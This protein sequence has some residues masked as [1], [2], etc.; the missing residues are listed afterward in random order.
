MDRSEHIAPTSSEVSFIWSIL[1]KWLWVLFM[2]P[3][4]EQGK[5]DPETVAVS[6]LLK[7]TVIVICNFFMICW[8]ICRKTI[9]LSTFLLLII[10]K[11]PKIPKGPQK[12]RSLQ[13]T[14]NPNYETFANLFCYYYIVNMHTSVFIYICYMYSSTYHM[15]IELIVPDL[16]SI[17]SLM[18]IIM[19]YFILFW[20]YM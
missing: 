17:I 18:D 20:E 7:Y 19:D 1:L 14:I 10:L 12:G 11:K 16:E 5:V 4:Q 13:M 15:Y 2:I 9:L 3:S 6:C 8:F